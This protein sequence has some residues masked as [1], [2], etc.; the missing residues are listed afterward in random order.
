MLTRDSATNNRIDRMHK[1]L[2]ITGEE[3]VRRVLH[4]IAAGDLQAGYAALVKDEAAETEARVWVEGTLPE[5]PDEAW[6]G[7][8]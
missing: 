4:C 1:K 6:F 3:D 5:L 7:S 2:T 8:D